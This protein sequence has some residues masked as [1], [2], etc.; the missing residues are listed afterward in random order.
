MA[1]HHSPPV[2]TEAKKLLLLKEQEITNLRESALQQL[3]HHFEQLKSDFQY[4]L[5]LLED[6]D[7]EL[8]RYDSEH[9]VLSAS[10]V[11]KERQL[12]SFQKLHAE[13]TSGDGEGSMFCISELRV[14]RAKYHEFEFFNQSKRS[15]L[16][17][18]LEEERLAHASALIKHREECEQAKR[19]LQRSLSEAEEELQ[20]Q[21]RDLHSQFQIKTQ[22]MEAMYK[23]QAE[24]AIHKAGLASKVAE[25]REDEARGARQRE[26]EQLKIAEAALAEVREKE[27][28]IQALNWELDQMRRLKEEQGGK[29]TFPWQLPCRRG[30]RNLR[31]FNLLCTAGCV[32]LQAASQ[33]AE[34]QL[35]TLSCQLAAAQRQVQ[36]LTE[37][38]T[39][40]LARYQMQAREEA[41]VLKV[42]LEQ[43]QSRNSE[44]EAEVNLLHGQLRAVKLDMQGKVAELEQELRLL[45]D[46]S[47]M[48]LSD[49]ERRR[50]SELNSI[51]EELWAQQQEGRLLR[52]RLEGQLKA[53]E[54]K[55]A[56]ISGFKERLAAAGDRERELQRKLV[57]VELKMEEQA[58]HFREALESEENGIMKRLMEQRDEA[59]SALQDSQSRLLDKESEIGQLRDMLMQLSPSKRGRAV[60]E[61]DTTTGNAVVALKSR[62]GSRL[63]PSGVE[64][65]SFQG[66]AGP[67]SSSSSR[68]PLTVTVPAGNMLQDSTDSLP[69]ISQLPSPTNLMLPEAVP[70]PYLR[71]PTSP[72]HQAAYLPG[73]PTW[74]G[75]CRPTSAAAAA[76]AAA[77]AGQY[78]RV[79]KESLDELLSPPA[80]HLQPGGGTEVRSQALVIGADAEQRHLLGALHEAE[81]QNE[82]LRN[83]LGIMRG[84]MEALQSAAAVASEVVLPQDVSTL[85]AELQESDRDIA[86][87]LEHVEVLQ[88]QLAIATASSS[89]SSP[90]G[91]NKSSKVVDAEISEPELSFLRRR[92]QQLLV[93]NRQLRRQCVQLKLTANQ[94]RLNVDSAGSAGS[95]VQ[96]VS[97]GGQAPD[98]PSS[99]G[100][101]VSAVPSFDVVLPGSSTDASP[102]RRAQTQEEELLRREVSDLGSEVQRLQSENGR[103]M[104]M[105]NALRAERDRLAE[106]AGRPASYEAEE[107]KFDMGVLPHPASPQPPRN[108]GHAQTPAVRSP[109]PSPPVQVPSPP[110]QQSTA[111]TVPGSMSA[112][113]TALTVPG[114]MSAQSTALTVPGS[115]SAQ[116]TALTVPG[117]MSAQ[118]YTLI[119]AVPT[120]AAAQPE[121]LSAGSITVHGTQDDMRRERSQAQQVEYV[122][123]SAVFREEEEE[124]GRLRSRRLAPGG[125]ASSAGGHAVHF[126]TDSSMRRG[127]SQQINAVGSVEND[128]G[129]SRMPREMRGATAVVAVA[130]ARHSSQSPN[131][132][133]S[134][135]FSEDRRSNVGVGSLQGVE[136]GSISPV[137]RPPSSI[138]GSASSRETLS[139]RARLRAIQRRAEEDASRPKVRNY[140]IREEG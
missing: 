76:A 110:V 59:N 95:A 81:V 48:A 90:P 34:S 69:D 21:A 20:R 68:A 45:R 111:L 118:P 104:E 1:L 96:P 126:F 38:G 52:E 65:T 84:E 5:K 72:S 6:R 86:Q 139:Q 130:R 29:G 22:Q 56:D 120:S 106:A 105:S 97:I 73:S 116:S 12:Q 113:S 80:S 135:G 4:N 27:K 35:L 124:A 74:L 85:Q 109:M 128:L 16:Q 32:V 100:L 30:A 114:S 13:V 41:A 25:Q 7:A 119:T 51:K 89:S 10:L 26:S 40:L 28:M 77:R 133:G 57:E 31:G 64:A 43:S 17:K 127:G 58:V 53:L 98:A 101:G 125:P 75:A 37:E 71:G 55:K 44:L 2:V 140:N 92:V 33:E 15:D 61:A 60:P 11:D 132:S 62:G 82:R 46:T 91:G 39:T 117:S 129:G 93:E 63:R 131:R 107:H 50:E 47:E 42:K 23:Q 94:S 78:L 122:P 70:S 123:S 138:P 19:V 54:E 49:Y 9:A 108:L 134:P 18:Q 88:K 137:A 3:E 8:E 83:T 102:P 112:Q 115:M 121:G 103:L 14:E 99:Q 66:G 24:D 36:E 79:S 67:S 136:A 87:T